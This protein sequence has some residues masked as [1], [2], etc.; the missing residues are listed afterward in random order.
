M[1]LYAYHPVQQA[2]ESVEQGHRMDAPEGTPSDVYHQVMWECWHYEPDD[3]P[4]FTEIVK[5]L[6]VI[7]PK[8][9]KK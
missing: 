6:K 1:L 7:L 2:R 4:T 5:T 3:R 9:P 8:L